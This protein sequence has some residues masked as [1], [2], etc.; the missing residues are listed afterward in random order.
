M[1]HWSIDTQA[2]ALAVREHRV[3]LGFT[4]RDA[5]ARSGIALSTFNRA[6]TK[7]P[8]SAANTLALCFWMDANPYSF[9]IDARTG[10]TVS[11]GITE[12]S[13]ENRD[14]NHRVRA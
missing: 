14:Y 12:T 13:A 2:F 10:A 5:Q 11:R 9:L 1:N 3:R 6:E 8:L 7:Q 4:M